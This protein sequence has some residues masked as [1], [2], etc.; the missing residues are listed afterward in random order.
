MQGKAAPPPLPSSTK[1]KADM[2]QLWAVKPAQQEVQDACKYVHSQRVRQS[3]LQAAAGAN[4]ADGTSALLMR[5]AKCHYR[6]VPLVGAV[7]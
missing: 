2:Q 1:L 4:P 3:Q 7:C 5:P 6:Q